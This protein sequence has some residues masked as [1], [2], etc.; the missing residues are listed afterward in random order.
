MQ[1][2][3]REDTGWW[4]LWRE[5][6]GGL[7]VDDRLGGARARLDDQLRLCQRHHLR[8][9]VDQQIAGLWLGPVDDHCGKDGHMQHLG[10]RLDRQVV[11]DDVGRHGWWPLRHWRD[12]GSRWAHDRVGPSWRR[13]WPTLTPG[14]GWPALPVAAPLRLDLHPPYRVLPQH[15][16]IALSQ[17]DIV[18]P[19]VKDAVPDDLWES[20]MTIDVT[21]GTRIPGP[22]QR[23]PFNTDQ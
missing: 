12:R 7:L 13:S 6:P 3:G 21:T 17:G 4:G 20:G 1:H 14:F 10:I 15:R 19:G 16:L 2:G 18:D 8:Y 23:L 11:H 9:E 22:T 5:G